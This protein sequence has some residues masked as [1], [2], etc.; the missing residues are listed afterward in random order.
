MDIQ[1]TKL[2][3]MQMLLDTQEENVLARVKMAFETDGDFW[4]ELSR[5]DQFAINDGIRQI[6]QG[7]SVSREEADRMVKERFNFS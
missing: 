7:E 2:E 3:L 1:A 5:E 6:E 4:E